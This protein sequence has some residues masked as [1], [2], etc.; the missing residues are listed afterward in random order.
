[1]QVM[2]DSGVRNVRQDPPHG[3]GAHSVRVLAATLVSL[4][5]RVRAAADVDD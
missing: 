2:A 1:M 5:Q 4:L 3:P